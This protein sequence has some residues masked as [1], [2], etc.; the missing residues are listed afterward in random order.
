LRGAQDFDDIRVRLNAI[1]TIEMQRSDLYR[2]ESQAAAVRLRVMLLMGLIVTSVLSLG[3]L[4]FLASTIARRVQQVTKAATRIADGD[5]TVRC[6]LP[7][8]NDEVGLMGATFN[9]RSG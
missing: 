7:A 6:E 5:N 1:R 3:A 8:S 2:Q 4:S 9:T